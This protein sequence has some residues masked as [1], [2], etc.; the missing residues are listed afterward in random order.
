MGL[1]S[2]FNLESGI[3]AEW[4][5]RLTQI[6]SIN[7]GIWEYRFNVSFT[8]HGPE[9]SDRI[10]D[11]IGKILDL[12]SGKSG[13]GPSSQEEML[14]QYRLLKLFKPDLSNYDS[15]NALSNNLQLLAGKLS[16]AVEAAVHLHDIGM[17][18]TDPD[19]HRKCQL[20][21]ANESVPQHYT[22]RDLKLLRDN[23]HKL[24]VIW[25]RNA[26]SGPATGATYSGRICAALKGIDDAV[27]STI[28]DA[29]EYHSKENIDECNEQHLFEEGMIVSK[30]A[31]L[32]IR[33][34]DE[35]DI[36]RKRIDIAQISQL[37]LEP[38]AEYWW[39]YHYLIKHIAIN[40]SG[41]AF[42]T[43]FNPTDIDIAKNAV[44]FFVREFQH[45]NGRII[46]LLADRGIYLSLNPFYQ[47]EADINQS[48]QAIPE[49]IKD[50]IRCKLENSR[51]A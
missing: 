15:R 32:L 22:N 1:L 2:L 47:P 6:K 24:S 31:V 21:L 29:C 26:L 41:V 50:R 14:C 13:L 46:G 43:S 23:H 37:R 7:K 49:H 5:G 35:L 12:S 28:M 51:R 39:W 30:I 42:Y 19:I 40:L 34:A 17:Q 48:T 27:I 38:D 8:D 11:F 18:C 44:E 20:T 25:L 9:H 36:S 45:K 16:F 33:I 4:E 3:R 10:T